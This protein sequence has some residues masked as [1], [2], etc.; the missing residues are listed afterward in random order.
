MPVMNL[1]R[2][3]DAA[4]IAAIAIVH[5]TTAGFERE[6]ARLKATEAQLRAALARDQNLLLQK[7]QLIQR[8]QILSRESDHRM[9]N[10]LQMIVSVL[11]MQSRMT[12]NAETA[13][14]LTAAANRVATI[15]R[16]H[17][18]LHCLDR[19]Q[20]V[21]F[22]AFLEELCRDLSAIMSSKDGRDQLV[23]EGVE[24]RLRSATG[25]PLGFIASELITNAAKHGKGRITV[26][27]KPN[28]AGGYVLS[29]ANEGP[30]LPDGFDPKS[31]KGLGMTIVSALVNQI[32][33]ELL[34]DRG[35]MEQGAR[36]AVHFA[37]AADDDA[38]R[39]T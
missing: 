33:G 11:S 26:S 36:F 38:P 22:K 23:V 4:P 15:E 1:S 10:G 24:V 37:N 8:Q 25:I 21:E 6:L 34:F 18:K 29:V 2:D 14:Q 32:G 3:T 9:L 39:S 30:P 19:V 16:V 31:Q 17:R 20:T 35:D 28:S 13:S 27:L 5:R 7:D 12:A